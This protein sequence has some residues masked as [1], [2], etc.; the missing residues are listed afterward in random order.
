MLPIESDSAGLKPRNSE[1]D[2]VRSGW[3]SSG[4]IKLDIGGS[5][6]TCQRRTKDFQPDFRLPQCCAKTARRATGWDGLGEIG[7]IQ[8]VGSTVIPEGIHQYDARKSRVIL[9]GGFNF[10]L[11][12]FV[13][14]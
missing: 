2:S 11:I 3:K 12:L 1:I 13:N 6:S 5:F 9:G 4:E 10:S 7:K 14:F 8:V